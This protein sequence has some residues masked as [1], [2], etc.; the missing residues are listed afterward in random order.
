MGVTTASVAALALFVATGAE[1]AFMAACGLFSLAMGAALATALRMLLL[2]VNVLQVSAILSSVNLVAYAG[3][4]VT[5]LLCGALL[6]ATSYVVVFAVMTLV[7]TASCA[8][9]VATVRTAR[10]RKKSKRL[11]LRRF[12][13]R[14]NAELAALDE[15]PSEVVAEDAAPALA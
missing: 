6:G 8:F 4:A 3:S 15:V 9:V 12:H 1:G 7:L 14:R 5:G 13:K 2:E 10:V 11:T